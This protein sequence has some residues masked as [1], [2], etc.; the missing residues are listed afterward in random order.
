MTPS[1]VHTALSGSYSQASSSAGGCD[2]YESTII[3]DGIILRLKDTS[4][5]GLKEIFQDIGEKQFQFIKMNKYFIR[6]GIAVGSRIEDRDDPNSAFIS[7]GL[8]RAVYIE[9]SQIDWP[10]IGTDKKNIERIRK[11]FEIEDKDEF[12][13]LKCGYNNR[14]EE[15]YFIDFIQQDEDYYRLVDDK[16]EEHR[17]E[18]AIRNKYIWLLRYFHHK[19]NDDTMHDSL[20]GIVL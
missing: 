6:G 4:F 8:A 2:Y 7:N 11:I 17:Q 18:Y 12:F 14:G 3:S 15:I 9:S 5:T 19:Y 10:V 1:G 20:K 16:R 13:G